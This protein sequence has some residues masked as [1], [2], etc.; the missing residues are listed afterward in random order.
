[1]NWKFIINWTLKFAL[2]I[3]VWDIAVWIT[4]S[5]GLAFC[6]ALGFLILFAIAE[7]YI[8]DWLEKRKDQEL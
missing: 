8:K 1:M 6:M 4:N 5:M 3:L 7:S 2:C